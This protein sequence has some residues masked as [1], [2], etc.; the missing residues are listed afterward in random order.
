MSKAFEREPWLDDFGYVLTA[1]EMRSQR[2]GDKFD[3]FAGSKP[4]AW[5]WL[6]VSA[7]VGGALGGT[8]VS[9]A[10]WG[11]FL[12][13][14]L[15]L[16]VTIVAFIL[17]R[18]ATLAVSAP[19]LAFLVGWTVFWGLLNGLVAMWGAQRAGAGRAYGI[20]GGM[21]FL[22]GIVQGGYE[23]EDLEGRDL[24]FVTGMVSAPLGACAA[25]WLHR[26]VIGDP[27]SLAAAAITGA[28]AGTLFLAPAMA[29]L[30]ARLNSVQ[31]LMR[32]ATLLLHRDDT[33]AEAVPILDRAI[34]IAPKDA[35][36]LDRRG[37]AHALS[38]NS[39]A[40]EAD[41]ARH[42]ERSPK[43]PAPDVAR[44]W[45]HLRR[46]RYGDATA[47]FEAALALSKRDR[48][49][50]IGLGLARLRSGDAAGAV[51]SLDQVPPR[52]LD[53]LSL[54][55]LAE[56]QLAAGNPKA[57]ADTA[58]EAID[59]LDSIFGRTWLVRAEA[60]RALGDIDG[61]AR[62]FNRAWHLADEESLQDRALAGLDA[63]G[64]PLDED[65]PEEEEP[66]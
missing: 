15:W 52:K 8:L 45:V 62:D 60:K 7:A 14:A 40:A 57:A 37:L 55:H 44:G 41:W 64:R 34:R 28:V 1:P 33:A 59:E 23:P 47:S 20:A 27:S 29:V 31:G 24:F 21:G 50:L 5:G 2:H 9:G 54:T 32:V 22:V 51:E 49:A 43:S 4:L 65:E 12:R 42:R 39:D 46:R 61:A 53:A 11:S 18:R 56:A 58:G 26:H 17:L 48:S 3:V 10:L 66:E 30:L 25:A 6:A 19:A 63:I 36:L 35:S 16:A 13:V 38:G